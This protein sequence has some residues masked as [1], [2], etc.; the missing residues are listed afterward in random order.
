M[1]DSTALTSMRTTTMRLTAALAL[2][3]IV[4]ALLGGAHA[5]GHR[6]DGPGFYDASCPLA[7]LGAI[8][9]TGGA[10]DPPASTPIAMAISVVVVALFGWPALT[11]VA[12][13][14]LRAPPAR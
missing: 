3:I 10:V 9:R 6:H 13:A 8:D 4:G 7:A 1:T 11:P 2:V 14:R 12:D 5:T